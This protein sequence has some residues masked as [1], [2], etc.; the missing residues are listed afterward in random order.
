[1]NYCQTG[2]PGPQLPH[3]P[4]QPGHHTRYCWQY[5]HPGGFLHQQGHADHQEHLHCQSRHLGH[6][7]L[8]LHNATDACGPADQGRDVKT[9]FS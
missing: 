9:H 5:R 4:L 8:F 3:C 1:M 7:P 6:S 2:P